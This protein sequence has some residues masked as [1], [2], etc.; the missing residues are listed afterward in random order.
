MDQ[1]NADVPNSLDEGD[2]DKNLT[3]VNKAFHIIVLNR[4]SYKIIINWYVPDNIILW[5]KINKIKKRNYKICFSQEIK[6]ISV[7]GSH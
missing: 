3:I 7:Q 4:E 6:K 2:S 1:K 5:R